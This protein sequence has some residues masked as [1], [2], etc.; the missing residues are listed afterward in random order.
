MGR[1][2]TFVF[3]G[4]VSSQS[5]PASRTV[6]YQDWGV[7]PDKP[8]KVTFAFTSVIQDI[9]PPSVICNLFLDL[10]QYTPQ[11]T[12][13]G[14]PPQAN[15]LGALSWTITGGANNKCLFASIDSNAPIYIPTRP[16]NNLVKIITRENIYPYGESE[17]NLVN[18]Q[19]TLCLSLEEW[20]T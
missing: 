15:Y 3:N 11:A 7:L 19:F 10:G 18:Q 1:I 17:Y 8:Y 6:F 9:N 14:N 20:E 13:T 2:H 12:V 4:A 5:Q 16:H